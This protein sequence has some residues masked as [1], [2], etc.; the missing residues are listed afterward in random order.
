M[1]L[2]AVLAIGLLI[3]QK[4]YNTEENKQISPVEFVTLAIMCIEQLLIGIYDYHLCAN[5][6]SYR[7]LTSLQY[8]QIVF[9][10]VI[11]VTEAMS[12]HIPL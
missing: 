8:F 4:K 10:L 1:V 11:I 7:C 6:D 2:S 9:I 12:H 3:E 5:L